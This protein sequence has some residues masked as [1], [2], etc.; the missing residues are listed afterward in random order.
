MGF[1]TSYLFHSCFIHA[2]YLLDYCF[3]AVSLLLHWLNAYGSFGSF[4]YLNTS[5]M[6]PHW[7]LFASSESEVDRGGIEEEQRTFRGEITIRHRF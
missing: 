2:S 5:S 3:I 1:N 7:V 4:C 6:S